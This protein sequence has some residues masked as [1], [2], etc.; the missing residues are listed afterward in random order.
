VQFE[1]TAEDFRPLLKDL[2][3]T[4]L[5]PRTPIESEHQPGHAERTQGQL[6]MCCLIA[7]KVA[8]F[9]AFRQDNRL[10]ER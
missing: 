9:H 10:A 1:K 7:C 8:G 6:T 4:T 5:Q 3:S 2:Q